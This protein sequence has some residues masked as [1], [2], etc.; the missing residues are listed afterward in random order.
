M[1][2]TLNNEGNT[3]KKSTIYLKIRRRTLDLKAF[4]PSNLKV[5]RRSTLHTRIEKPFEEVYN[6]S[7]RTRIS[8]MKAARQTPESRTSTNR[9]LI[10]D[11][12][13]NAYYSK[14]NF[15]FE[16]KSNFHNEAL[17][18][19]SNLCDKE[20]TITC[21]LLSR[22]SKTKKNIEQDLSEI[23]SKDQLYSI[24]DKKAITMDYLNKPID[25]KLTIN[26]YKLKE[27]L[28]S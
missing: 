20:R 15:K 10:S 12:P 9:A 18:K 19:V 26:A 25:R 23:C 22:I 24:Y 4:I 16:L 8:K 28:I 17:L 11:S 14:R 1:D 3:T 13:S 5:Q 21:K 7:P 2:T 6:L 27:N